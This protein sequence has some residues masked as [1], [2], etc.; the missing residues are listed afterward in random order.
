MSPWICEEG[1]EPRVVTSDVVAP[2][3]PFRGIVDASME[4]DRESETSSLVIRF[5]DTVRRANTKIVVE[6]VD[7]SQPMSTDETPAGLVIDGGFFVSTTCSPRSDVNGPQVDGSATYRGQLAVV[8]V[9]WGKTAR[10]EGHSGAL[11]ESDEE[12]PIGPAA[13]TVSDGLGSEHFALGTHANGIHIEAGDQVGAYV[14]TRYGQKTPP[15]T[16]KLYGDSRSF[17]PNDTAFLLGTDGELLAF[18]LWRFEPAFAGHEVVVI[19]MRTGE[20]VACGTGAWGAFRLFSPRGEGLVVPQIKL[21][22]SGWLDVFYRSSGD[23]DCPRDLDDEFFDFL[24]AQPVPPLPL[25]MPASLPEPVRLPS[26]P[27]P[28]GPFGGIVRSFRRYNPATYSH[29]R[30][31]QYYDSGSGEVTEIVFDTEPRPSLGTPRLVDEGVLF[32]RGW[33]TSVLIPWGSA[34]ELVA[35]ERLAR[36]ARAPRER[37]LTLAQFVAEPDS[38]MPCASLPLDVGGSTVRAKLTHADYGDRWHRPELLELSVGD[39]HGAYLLGSPREGFAVPNEVRS[40]CDEQW[41]LGEFEHESDID[42]YLPRLIGSDG[43]VLM[44][45]WVGL[46]GESFFGEPHTLITYVISLRTGE[47]L[48][49]GLE[50][51]GTD[52][53]FVPATTERSPRFPPRL[54]PSGWL[55]PTPCT[56]GERDIKPED[57]TSIPL[58]HGD[59]FVCARELDFRTIGD[60]RPGIGPTPAAFGVRAAE[61]AS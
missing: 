53:V 45:S 31:V 51:F 21:P 4:R 57:C 7:P 34:P 15:A 20:V 52:V 9:P 11:S 49:C 5:H 24:A 23:G 17:D 40:E 29:D 42:G 26:T 58:G 59:E 18:A 22:P 61:A 54:P 19:S 35:A 32:G 47:V 41:F 13:L 10:L 38:V 16:T 25:P 28:E 44:V 48:E 50:P 8:I 33:G 27:A 1:D 12:A 6:G 30:V 46:P 43:V 36:L 39:V 56:H 14:L 37:G 60:S 2:S 55:D 3:L